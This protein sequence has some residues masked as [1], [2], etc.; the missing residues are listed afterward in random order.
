[1]VITGWKGY[2][3]FSITINGR[4]TYGQISAVWVEGY[5][6]IVDAGDFYYTPGYYNVGLV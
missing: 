1:M 6:T 5:G 2:I 4:T 3:P